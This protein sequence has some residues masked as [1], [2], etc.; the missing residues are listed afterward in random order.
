MQTPTTNPIIGQTA[1]H[2]ATQTDN[3]N[4]TSDSIHISDC[5]DHSTDFNVT[6]GFYDFEMENLPPEID[7]HDIRVDAEPVHPTT[8]KLF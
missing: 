8:S 4:G 6:D 1:S 5:S 2:V 3:E 7:D